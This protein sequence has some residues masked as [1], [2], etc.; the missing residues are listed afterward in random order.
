MGLT[1]I[2]SK[3]RQRIFSVGVVRSLNK[4]EP[5][6]ILLV[7]DDPSVAKSLSVLLRLAKHHVEVAG[8]CETAL[9]RYEERKY[10]LVITDFLMPGIDGLE[11]ARLI[12]AR[13]PQQAILLITGHLEKVSNN[14]KARLRHVDGLLAKPFSQPQLHEALKM[15]FLKGVQVSRAR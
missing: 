12:R 1:Q 5:K 13:V 9:N 4:I 3:G 6:S 14:E 15:M 2:P 10:D 11:L 7:E 8:D